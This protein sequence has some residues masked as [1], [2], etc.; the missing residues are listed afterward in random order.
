MSTI[1]K[2][3][4]SAL[5]A[6]LFGKTRQAVLALFFGHS[7]ESFYVRE[8]V[9]LVGA[10]HGAV[11]RELRQLAASGI[12]KRSVDGHQVYYRANAE[13]AIFEDLCGLITKT[14]GAASA[15]ADALQS[16]AKRIRVAFVYGSAAKGTLQAE[17]DL[18]LMV[19]GNVRF[20]T[21]VKACRPAAKKLRREVNVTVYPVSEFSTKLSDGHHFI[22]SV[23]VDPK[24]FVFGGEDELTRLTE[25]GMAH[26]ARIES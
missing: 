4:P 2:H 21:V 26:G 19:I 6:A 14:A 25:S 3:E 18:D 17:S 11:Q 7:D 24:V 10:G 16:L 13:S 12:I 22:K 5:A 20:S 15:F 9:R 1:G 23:M 8:V